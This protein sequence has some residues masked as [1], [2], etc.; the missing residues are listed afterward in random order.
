MK[1]RPISLTLEEKL[2]EFEQWITASIQQVNE[3]ET[4]R[5]ELRKISRIFD[6]LGAATNNFESV[7]DCNSDRMAVYCIA[8]VEQII[9]EQESKDLALSAAS[10]VLDS[11]I[12]M[13]FLVTGKSDNNMK[14]QFPVYLLQHAKRTSFPVFQRR[15]R[16]SSFFNIEELGR[17]IKQEKICR[18][19]SDALVLRGDYVGDIDL[20]SEAT[21]LLKGY[22]DSILDGQESV[23][24]LW[25]LGFSYFHLKRNSPGLEGKLLAPIVA[26]KVRGSVAAQSGHLP[27]KIL[28]RHMKMW[29][30]KP[31]IDFNTEDVIVRG[32]ELSDSDLQEAASDL[33][34]D[35]EEKILD[36]LSADPTKTRAYDFVLPYGTPG[37]GWSIFVQ[38]QFYAGDSGSVS[39]KVV[40]QTRSSRILTRAKY[41]KAIFIEYLD[42]AGYYAS[43]YRDLRHMLEMP[44]TADFIQVRSSHI[45]L[46][47]ALQGIGFLTPLEF[48]HA[49]FQRNGNLIDAMELLSSEGYLEQEI[50]R[51]LEYCKTESLI[52]EGA[53][54]TKICP[55]LLVNSRRLLLLDLILIN[56][57]TIHPQGGALFVTVPGAGPKYGISFS[58]LGRAY[59]R[60][61]GDFNSSATR[62]G[63]DMGWLSNNGYVQLH[64]Y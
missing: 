20:E 5:K 44:S 26:F 37:W 43:L 28:R 41:P 3:T 1:L 8:E 50:L 24:Q 52:V 23:E 18:L 57:E 16:G 19:I 36:D 30:L 14:C 40:D 9:L 56:G 59:E 13:L 34:E 6:S 25:S 47:R 31:G 58:T 64:N 12:S 63:L 17:V 61:L 2:S 54:A 27:E 33:K 15:A 11:L 51:C 62:F 53:N 32:D 55:R 42:G 10:D 21:W 49:L 45:K 38:A 46:R 7:E 4:Y 48:V 29:G 60:V 39:H 22:I 35:G